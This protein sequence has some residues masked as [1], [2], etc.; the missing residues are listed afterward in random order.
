MS[1]V[2]AR[3][4]SL[5]RR[6]V[7]RSTLFEGSDGLVWLA[8]SESRAPSI[9]SFFCGD[10]MR[11]SPKGRVF[12]RR[13]PDEI[14]R[15]VG[16]GGLPILRLHEPD[17]SLE[18]ILRRA[19]TIPSLVDIHVDLPDDVDALRAQ[20]L[21]STTR[22]DFRR[23]RK[24]GFDYRITSDPAAVR[25][26]HA[27]HYTPVVAQRLPD[28][29]AVRSVEEMVRDVERGGEIVCADIDGTWVAGLLN[30]RNRSSYALRSL[31]I[32]DADNAIRQKRVTAALIVRSLE[33]AVE[34][35]QKEAS[36]G[37]SVPFLGKGPVWFKA[38]WG[39]IVS[40][41]RQTRYLH[42]FMDLRNPAIR[43]M[44]STTP[45]IHVDDGELVVS[46][47]LE[48][49]DDPLRVTVRDAGRFPGVSQ[50]YVLGEPDT[51]AAGA[52]QLAT[53]DRI[54]PVPVAPGGDRPLWLG[55]TIRNEI[56]AA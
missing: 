51:L 2:L 48:P 4:R 45:I 21:T 11:T 19:V 46:M 43:R 33:R 6:N 53:S 31:G 22:E 25:E 30:L 40:C 41:G 54:V 34:L 50:W 37:R 18:D 10:E 49:G 12:R 13:I 56:V 8:G 55:E 15:V 36:L 28:D 52:E 32:R 3:A 7:L 17:P 35:G 20:L 9:A 1:R 23:I 5:L 27:K 29:G 39:G 16:A 42:M 24:A 44:L 26:F 14:D 38:K 47:W